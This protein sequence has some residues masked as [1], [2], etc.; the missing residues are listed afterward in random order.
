GVEGW[1]IRCLQRLDESDLLVVTHPNTAML[2][3]F[4]ALPTLSLICNVRDPITGQPYSRDPRFVA[5]KAEK[6]L[7]STGIADTS[8]WGPEIE[9][10]IFD[11]I[12]F[13]QSYNYGFYFIDS[14]EGAW[15]TGS[16][17]GPN[18]GY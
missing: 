12:R 11:N 4:T 15:N 13:D 16:D 9:F 14:E 18:L 10:Y 8:Y 2:D 5:Q 6:Y 3:P 17:A 7:Q 1:S